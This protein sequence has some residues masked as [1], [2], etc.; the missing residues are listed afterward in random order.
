MRFGC[1]R[2]V[3]AIVASQVPLYAG[4]VEPS[5]Y[6]LTLAIHCPAQDIYAGDE[7]PIVFTI[8]NRD[9]RAFEYESRSYDRSGRM[10]EY[11]LAAVDATG[12]PVPDPRLDDPPGIG[13]GLSGGPVPLISGRSFDR[14]I[15]LN[16][17]SRIAKPG[18]Y[19]VKGTYHCDLEDPSI[20]TKD[21]KR[22]KDFSVVASPIAITV[23]ARSDAE[24][25]RYIKSLTQEL[26]ALPQKQAEQESLVERL[27]YTCDKRIVPTMLGIMRKGQPNNEVFWAALAFTCYLPRDPEIKMTVVNDAKSHGLAANMQ[28]VLE[29]LGCD[30]QDFKRIIRVSLASSDPSVVA[31]AA[32]AAQEHPSDEYMPRLI[33]IATDPNHAGLGEF[34]GIAQ[35]RAT[36]ALAN[37]RTDEGV[38]ALRSLLNHPNAG[39]RRD[40]GDS[41]RFAYRR[42]P[43]YPQQ[44][45]QELT[46]LLVRATRDS[47]APTWTTALSAIL[48]TRTA[49]GVAAIKALAVDPNATI[50]PAD[51]DACVQAVR[52]LLRAP[53]PRMRSETKSWIEAL[54]HDFPGRPLRQDDFPDEFRGNPEAIKQSVLKLLS[55]AD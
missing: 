39:I 12:T 55:T 29:R 31:E 49:G 28:N 51:A 4:G 27:A 42:H 18:T 54:Y 45:D 41:I 32:I 21:H 7:I 37:N 47:N 10:P 19:T 1:L 25:G 23:R 52:D 44:I 46:D 13:G 50:S 14:T 30:E 40:A 5:P 34:A 15:A 24:M 22:V 11:E 35:A 2:V 17:W 38:A 26:A 9:E 20:S 16:L 33:L 3:A 8:T 6:D 36:C 53:N 48:R 43:G